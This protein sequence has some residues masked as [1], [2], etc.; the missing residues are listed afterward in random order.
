MPG[1][2]ERFSRVHLTAELAARHELPNVPQVPGILAQ[3]FEHAAPHRG[4][5]RGHAD[6]LLR[7]ELQ[8][9]GLVDAGAGQHQV[10][11]GEG[12]GER[13]PPGHGMVLRHGGEHD[14]RLTQAQGVRLV[15]A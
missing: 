10:G 14:V 13:Q 5:G 6:L 7:D 8:Q 1:F 4:D 3:L 2:S 12:A 11:A 15:F 9:L